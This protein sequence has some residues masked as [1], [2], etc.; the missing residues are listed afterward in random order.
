VE[1]D[2]SG[3]GFGAVLQQGVGPLAFFSVSGEGLS[4][5]WM[6]QLGHSRLQYIGK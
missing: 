1:C 5:N 6:I 2:A 3:I 4:R